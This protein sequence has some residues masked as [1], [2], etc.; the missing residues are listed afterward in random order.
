RDWL[1]KNATHP[2]YCS[3]ARHGH[4]LLALHLTELAPLNNAQTFEL[5]HH[6]L[7]A[8]PYK[9]MHGKYIPEVTRLL[10]MAGADINAVD[11]ASGLTALHKAVAAGNAHL[12]SLFLSQEQPIQEESQ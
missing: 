6:L 7:K 5:T 3:D 12:V 1:L 8:H 10:F 11:P 9:Y 2:K 4:I